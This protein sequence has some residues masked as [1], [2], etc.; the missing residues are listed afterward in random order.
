MSF[1]GSKMSFGLLLCRDRAAK[2]RFEQPGRTS[3]PE[4]LLSTR[5]PPGSSIKTITGKRGFRIS[6][7]VGHRVRVRFLGYSYGCTGLCGEP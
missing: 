2:S 6:R 3:L 7:W 4:H 1:H 5:F